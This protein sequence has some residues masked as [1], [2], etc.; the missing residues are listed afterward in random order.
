MSEVP[1]ELRYTKEHEW[2]RVEGDSVVIGVTDYAQNALTDVVWVELPEMGAVV[3]SMDSFASVESVKSVSEIYAPISGE[4][5]EINDV[6]EDSPELIN[7][8][9]YGKGWICKMSISD[10]SELASLLDG[11]T[12]RGLIEE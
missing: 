11:T 4:V 6:L 5:I 3:G 7:E 1:E 12:Y 9:P 8:D 2:I 10:N